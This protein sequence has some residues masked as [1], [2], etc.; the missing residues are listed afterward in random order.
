MSNSRRAFI[1]LLFALPIMVA[2]NKEK[3]EVEAILEFHGDYEVDGCGFFIQLDDE[4]Y[5]P[6]DESIIGD[7][8]K[9]EFSTEVIIDYKLPDKQVEYYCGFS[10]SVEKASI[11]LTSIKKK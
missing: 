5:K 11:E 10:G 9:D 4:M 8:F 6:T 7:E 1:L 2:C 3:T